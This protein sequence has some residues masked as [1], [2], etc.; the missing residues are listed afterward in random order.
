MCRDVPNTPRPR[1]APCDHATPQTAA[2]ASPII[3]VVGEFPCAR[4]ERVP[5]MSPSLH[6]MPAAREAQA[7]EAAGLH[8]ERI[9]SRHHGV[10]FAQPSRSAIGPILFAAN[11]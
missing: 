10:G 8:G 9:S 11:R 1:E 2:S 5:R 3:A 7:R 6:S 4:R